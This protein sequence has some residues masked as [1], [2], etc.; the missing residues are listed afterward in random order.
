MMTD[1]GQRGFTLIEMLI[2]VA[3]LGILA[4]ILIPNFI[5]SRAASHLAAC[6]LDLRNIAAA[7]QLFSGENETYPDAASWESDLTTGG[8]I[9]GM[10]RSPIDGAAYVYATNAG[11]NNFVISDGPDK[12]QQ[13][14]ISG[15][16]V[17]TPAGGLEV[18]LGSVPSP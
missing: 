15:Y 10:P 16:I 9:R 3:I 17:Y 1:R 12:Y 2:V 13:A 4:A 14:G 6:Q 8:Y 5:R 7:L 18:G 11:R